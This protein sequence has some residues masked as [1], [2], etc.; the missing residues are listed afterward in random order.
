MQN[1]TI[2]RAT[3]ND[4]ELI[5][6][7]GSTTFYDTFNGTCTIADMKY[8][9]DLYYNQNQVAKELNDETDFFYVAFDEHEK[10]LGY[11]RIKL[12]QDYPFE[13]LNNFKAIELKRLYCISEAK[14]KGVAKAL[15][16]HAF[17]FAKQRGYNKMYLSVWEYNIRAQEFYKKMSFETTGIEN[18]FPLGTTPQTDFWFWKNL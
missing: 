17:E 16:Q 7:L 12:Q 14:G 4:V 5:S 3:T 11:Y 2:R 9:L 6:T 13:A 18:D 1:I 10:A 8:V 15:M